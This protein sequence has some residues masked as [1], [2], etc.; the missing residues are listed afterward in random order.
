MSRSTASRAAPKKRS[1]GQV[2]RMRSGRYQARYTGPDGARHSAPM[3]FEAKDDAVAWLRGE[4][5]RVEDPETWEP[6]KLRL[7]QSQTRLTFG[8]YADRWLEE[9][10]LKP[11]TRA[12]YRRLLDVQLLPTFGDMAL[13]KVTADLV[14]HWHALMGPSR[15]ALRAH[16]YALLRTILGEAEQDQLIS[17]NPCHIRGAGNTRRVHRVKPASLEELT[18]LVNAM[19]ERL[20]VMTLLA[21]WC[22]LRFGELAELRRKDVDLKAGQL[23]IRRAVV[24]VNG[25]TIVDTP[26]TDAGTRDVAIPPHL[27]DAVEK[28]LSTHTQPGKDGLLFPAADGRHL[29]PSTLYGRKGTTRKKGSGFYEARSIA[30]RDDLRW[31]DLRHTGAVL[32]ASTGAT[33]AELMARLGHSTPAAAMRYQH[34]AE[35]RDLEIARKLSALAAGLGDASLGTV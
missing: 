5:P 9:R 10:P 1:F 27:L 2:S 31:H 26:K 4:R 25:R 14:N 11:R 28:H 19:P 16:S 32:A 15:P 23:R 18:T 6:P 33:L 22:G 24:R 35:G 29:N 12:H 21:A 3:T 7:E 13:T 8:Q 20:Q 30:G 17:R 34:A